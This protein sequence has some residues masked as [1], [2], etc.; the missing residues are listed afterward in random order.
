MHMFDR[1]QT[2]FVTVWVN[3]LLTYLNTQNGVA[4][5]KFKQQNERISFLNKRGN[6]YQHSH[7]KTAIRLLY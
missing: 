3:T 5:N 2:F 1:H 4:K 7:S 6:F